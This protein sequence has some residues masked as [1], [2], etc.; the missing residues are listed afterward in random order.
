M[1]WLSRVCSAAMPSARKHRH[2]VSALVCQAGLRSYSISTE[3]QRLLGH[4]EVGS[5]VPPIFPATS[6]LIANF[7]GIVTNSDFTTKWMVHKYDELK[8]HSTLR[9]LPFETA[10]PFLA[11]LLY[12][13]NFGAITRLLLDYDLNDAVMLAGSELRSLSIIDQE[14][15]LFGLFH[16]LR[17]EGQLGLA[18]QIVAELG[19][20]A[21]RRKAFDELILLQSEMKRMDGA[22][23]VHVV[24]ICKTEAR[25]MR[26]N[27]KHDWLDPLTVNMLIRRALDTGEDNFARSL[28][29]ECWYAQ[30]ATRLFFKEQSEDAVFN[31]FVSQIKAGKSQNILPLLISRTGKDVLAR[32]SNVN[33]VATLSDMLSHES[34]LDY[35][36]ALRFASLQGSGNLCFARTANLDAK[37]LA[38]IVFTFVEV[39][40][41][42]PPDRIK[43]MLQDLVQF[44][45]AAGRDKMTDM[46]AQFSQLIRKATSNRRE[47]YSA[48]AFFLVLRALNVVM[49]EIPSHLEAHIR[50]HVM[51][52]P[53]AYLLRFSLL[54]TTTIRS[55]LPIVNHHLRLLRLSMSSPEQKQVDIPRNDSQLGNFSP[56]SKVP[57]IESSIFHTLVLTL[58]KR[59]RRV[60]P[61]ESIFVLYESILYSLIQLP[62]PFLALSFIFNTRTGGIEMQEKHGKVVIRALAIG[63]RQ[64]AIY[65]LF[66]HYPLSVLP[67]DTYARHISRISSSSPAYAMALLRLLI[68]KGE[69]PRP[70]LL[71][72]LMTGISE[73][74]MIS[75]GR[76][77]RY[78][79]ELSKLRASLNYPNDR[80][81]L[82][83]FVRV[84]LLR[85]GLGAATSRITW[86]LNHSRRLAQRR[87]SN[88]AIA[89]HL[90]L[91]DIVRKW[92]LYQQRTSRQ[93]RSSDGERK[94]PKQ[95]ASFLR[96]LGERRSLEGR[97]QI[98]KIAAKSGSG[99]RRA[100]RVDWRGNHS[101]QSEKLNR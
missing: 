42:A 1:Q 30:E 69:Q 14:F 9:C 85:Q 21:G 80:F 31:V 54:R 91:D 56:E 60:N 6:Q 4:F 3:A 17:S 82:A 95:L 55:L 98:P 84:V 67:Y 66:T 87:S 90:E 40:D 50:E 33:T 38:M 101:L 93:P 89:R 25:H 45:K 62:Q 86:L 63:N 22:S 39:V 96:K 26:Y 41:S 75:T 15:C 70:R 2:K 49:N 94:R 48:A 35:T 92:R 32:M 100:R 65:K 11:R 64:S 57:L 47:D 7:H 83:A 28:C 29:E 88:V 51:H 79:E 68:G 16:A 73:S 13:R 77:F 10:K 19:V 72:N 37:Q 24:E 52:F 5:S 78:L 20:T 53:A 12:R 71:Q 36:F 74:L 27:T 81:Q 44:M 76:A 97:G 61:P 18:R 46:V 58:W 34:D 23:L 59:Q 43:Q 99:R 8:R